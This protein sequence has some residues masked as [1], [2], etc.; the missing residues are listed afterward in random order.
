MYN[1]W[2]IEASP[3]NDA[4]YK[5]VDACRG[6]IGICFRPRLQPSILNYGFVVGNKVQ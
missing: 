1:I 2:S 6:G 4:T 3:S 5:S